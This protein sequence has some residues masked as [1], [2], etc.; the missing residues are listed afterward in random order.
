[1]YN[2]LWIGL[3]RQIFWTASSLPQHLVFSLRKW[4]WNNIWRNLGVVSL[5]FAVSS[6]TLFTVLSIE[7]AII[8]LSAN[9][10]LEWK[11][12]GNSFRLHDRSG[13]L[14][15]LELIVRILLRFFSNDIFLFALWRSPRSGRV[16]NGLLDAFTFVSFWVVRPNFI[17]MVLNIT[18]EDC[19]FQS[20]H[21]FTSFCRGIEVISNDS[22]F[23]QTLDSLVIS[24][25]HCW[26]H[27]VMLRKDMADKGFEHF[28]IVDELM[29]IRYLL[30]DELS[31][32][33]D[34]IN[35]KDKTDIHD[36]QNCIALFKVVVD[37]SVRSNHSSWSI[38]EMEWKC[39]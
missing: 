37:S 11:Q 30:Q 14:R 21:S 1:M 26:L 9:W 31:G 38:Y 4:C 35:V 33:I 36:N 3:F 27:P 5:A 2:D 22:L 39:I 32:L 20:V 13:C 29:V 7:A 10:L 19:L 6:T 15:F 18:V 16:V 28:I 17:A 34:L 24:L 23:G 12:V 8:D 25:L